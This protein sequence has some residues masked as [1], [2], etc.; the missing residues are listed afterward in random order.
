MKTGSLHAA[1]DRATAHAWADFFAAAPPD[2]AAE[3]GLAHEWRGGALFFRARD[4]PR[5]LFNQAIGL[6]THEPATREGV[7]EAVEFFRSHSIHN[8]CITRVPRAEPPELGSWLASHGLVPRSHYPIHTRVADLPLDVNTNLSVSRA[9][10]EDAAAVARILGAVFD[11]PAWMEP[12]V[13]AAVTRPHWHYFL[14]RDGKHPVGVGALFVQGDVGW[15]GM[16]GTL[17]SHRGQG[18]Q[19]AILSRRIQEAAELGCQLLV[20]ETAQDSPDRP[21]PSYRNV[22]RSGFRPLFTRSVYGPPDPSP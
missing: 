5:G 6:G 15:F 2:L 12:W 8:F 1:A 18:A 16:G 9:T 11:M 3:H 19:R 4:L 10:P 21:N 14:A 20:C 17:H 7:A 22:T 13:A